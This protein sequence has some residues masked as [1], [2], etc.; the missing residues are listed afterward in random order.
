MTETQT[1]Q[2]QQIFSRLM[3][4]LDKKN[5]RI[6]WCRACWSD[7]RDYQGEHLQDKLDSDFEQTQ[8]CTKIMQEEIDLG[9]NINW[10]EQSSLFTMRFTKW[11]RFG[12][13]PQPEDIVLFSKNPYSEEKQSRGN[14]PIFQA[15]YR[16]VVMDDSEAQIALH[17][18]TENGKRLANYFENMQDES[19]EKF[20]ELIKKFQ[21]FRDVEGVVR[22]C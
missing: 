19:V 1:I 2:E 4:Y 21:Q 16:Q 3:D 7:C 9:Y 5:E 6:N 10:E 15:V 18:L 22:V 20:Q 13:K 14:L 8:Y 12:L 17:D 11:A